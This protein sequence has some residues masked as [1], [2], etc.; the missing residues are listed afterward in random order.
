MNDT[1]ET[2]GTDE[3]RRRITEMR[4]K[5]RALEADAERAADPEERRRLQREVRRLE[6]DSEQASMMAA[7]D[8]Y[9]TQ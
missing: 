4:E 9:P 3:T 2:G 6:F 8:I 5:A 1:G 7:G